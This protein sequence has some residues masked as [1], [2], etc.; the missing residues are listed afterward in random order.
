VA[1]LCSIK[2]RYALSLQRI[3]LKI[4]TNEPDFIQLV[5]EPFS[6]SYGVTKT[7]HETEMKSILSLVEF[8]FLLK[9]KIFLT[10]F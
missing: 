5:I 3:V 6:P 8:Y 4:D 10:I 7:N 2:A 1:V 9:S